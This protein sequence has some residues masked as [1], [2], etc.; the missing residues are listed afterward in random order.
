M[1]VQHTVAAWQ[2]AIVGCL[3]DNRALAAGEAVFGDELVLMDDLDR[4]ASK[5][6]R[7]RTYPTDVSM[8]YRVQLPRQLKVPAYTT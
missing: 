3:G 6:S 5:P 4:A 1:C 2:V 7:T 8:G